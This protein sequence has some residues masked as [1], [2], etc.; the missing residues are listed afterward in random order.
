MIGKKITSIPPPRVFA[1]KSSDEEIFKELIKV[2]K[3]KIDFVGFKPKIDEIPVFVLVNDDDKLLESVLA[4]LDEECLD[5]NTRRWAKEKVEP[6]LPYI[7]PDTNDKSGEE[8]VVN[9]IVVRIASSG[10]GYLL[11]FN[12]VIGA[13]LGM[14]DRLEM[15]RR[16]KTGESYNVQP[17]KLAEMSRVLFDEVKVRCGVGSAHENVRR[18]KIIDAAIR[19]GIIDLDGR[20]E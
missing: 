3:E 8:L 2:F 7:F 1:S 18:S 12:H 9:L 19:K 13:F 11:C 6:I 14:F 17:R 4:R 16:W 10:D 5:E 20:D 15:V